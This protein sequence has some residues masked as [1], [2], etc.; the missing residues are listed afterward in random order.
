MRAYELIGEIDEERQ[1]HAKLP[2]NV[3]PP[4]DDVRVIV[5]LPES[6]DEAETHWAKG[7]AREWAAELDDVREDIYNLQDG[8]PIDAAR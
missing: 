7:V 3:T 8:E 2:A 4:Y 6:Q 1:I 5:L